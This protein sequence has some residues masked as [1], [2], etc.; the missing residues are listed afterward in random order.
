MIIFDTNLI[1]L[2]VGLWGEIWEWM[3]L[4]MLRWKVFNL[5]KTSNIHVAKTPQ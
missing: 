1:G 5:D 4:I 2:K 3:G